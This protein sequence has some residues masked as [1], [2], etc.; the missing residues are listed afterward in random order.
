MAK[1]IK[2]RLILTPGLHLH[3]PAKD[4]TIGKRQCIFYINMIE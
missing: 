3:I 2:K 4:Y 1:Q